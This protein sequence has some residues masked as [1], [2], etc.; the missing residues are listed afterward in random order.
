ME[1]REGPSM[2]H[3]A[4]MYFLMPLQGLPKSEMFNIKGHFVSLWDKKKN[5]ADWLLVM[6]TFYKTASLLRSGDEATF[7]QWS[8]Y[9]V[10]NTSG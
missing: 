9:R 2:Q 10:R 7:L 4:K 1:V 3:C 5:V 8:L 6:M